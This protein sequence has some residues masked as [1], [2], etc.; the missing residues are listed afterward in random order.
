MYRVTSGTSMAAPMVSGV[1]AEVLSLS[2]L[3]IPQQVVDVLVRGGEG[4]RRHLGLSMTGRR[5]N[6]LHALLLGR[7]LF[8]FPSHHHLYLKGDTEETLKIEFDASRLPPGVYTAKLL[9]V[10]ARQKPEETTAATGATAAAAAAAA[11][12]AKLSPARGRLV[13]IVSVQVPLTLH[14]L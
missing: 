4:D 9:L 14:V 7:L 3:A 12:A 10:Y 6:A 5:L 11:A 8:A 2:P 13:E 1:A